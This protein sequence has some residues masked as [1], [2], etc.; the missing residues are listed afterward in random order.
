M[1][2]I[3]V[4]YLAWMAEELGLR[5]G[6]AVGGTV[7]LL[8]SMPLITTLSLGQIYPILA[9]GL[10]AAWVAERRGKSMAAGFALGFVITIR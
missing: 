8:L 5:A 3:S 10:V 7:M 9:F 2:R 1:L 4:V 6:W